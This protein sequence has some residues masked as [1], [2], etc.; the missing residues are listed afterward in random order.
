MGGSFLICDHEHKLPPIE[1]GVHTFTDPGLPSPND[2][3]C[4]YPPAKSSDNRVVSAAFTQNREH[5]Y[6]GSCFGQREQVEVVMV[7]E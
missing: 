6:V 5:R 4:T 1:T 2:D 3:P 7:N